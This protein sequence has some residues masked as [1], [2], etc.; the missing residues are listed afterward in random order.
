M[1]APGGSFDLGD[2]LSAVLL[3]TLPT[4]HRGKPDALGH[5]ELD[6][7]ASDSARLTDKTAKNPQ[8]Q[9]IR[10]SA[11]VSAPRMGRSHA[12]LGRQRRC[13]RGAGA[14]RPSVTGP[15]LKARAFGIR[16]LL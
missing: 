6:P 3:L 10:S 14:G 2:L 11:D 7:Y 15:L 5:G 13:R 1:L 9:G 8:L 4:A 16:G 12:Y